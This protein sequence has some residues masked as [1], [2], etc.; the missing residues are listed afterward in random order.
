[1]KNLLSYFSK[2]NLQN[3]GLSG[4]LLSLIL[5]CGHVAQTAPAAK[6]N[7]CG[8]FKKGA[9][10]FAA[11]ETTMGNFKIKLYPDKAPATV[12]NFVCLAEGTKEWKDPKT[13]KMKKDPFYD[14][15]I[16]HR[17]IDGFMIQGGCPKGDGTGD[18]GYKFKDEPN[19]LKHKGPG[20]LSMANAGP[21]T[22]GSQFFITLAATPW[23]DGKHTIFG[24]VSEGLDVVQKI[25]KTK[26]KPGDRP[27]EDIK[28]KSVKIIRE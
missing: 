18:P 16:F 5:T 1:M 11:F 27:V 7:K 28:I 26:V 10:V 21:N 19:D 25:G 2:M 13:G 22:N 3:V 6:K 23:L 8:P 20:T 12:E 4:I 17:V 9:I 14:G 15:L 24:E